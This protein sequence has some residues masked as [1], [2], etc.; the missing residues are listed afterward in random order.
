V[1][2]AICFLCI[3]IIIAPHFIFEYI[4]FD[5]AM[6]WVAKYF[7]L[8]ILLVMAP[9]SYYMYFAYI[10]QR[11]KRQY[12]SKFWTNLRSIF[13]I[14]TL[15]FG[16]SMI[17]CGVVMM[18]IFLTNAYPYGGRPIMVHD[19]IVNVHS[20]ENRG[21]R[22]YF[23]KIIDKRFNRQIEFEVGPGY[24][25]GDTFTKKME[26]GRWGLLYKIKD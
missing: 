20:S 4:E 3:L 16:L 19:E 15:V 10:I 9:L 21:Q 12:T 6:D 22:N 14:V 18:L 24:H 8:P 25:V 5:P 7:A 1:F 17:C 26:V 23:I 13:R 2:Y 11:E